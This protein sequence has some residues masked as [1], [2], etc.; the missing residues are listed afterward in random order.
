MSCR[1]GRIGAADPSGQVACERPG[2]RRPARGQDG[3]QAGAGVYDE[4]ARALVVRDEDVELTA[5]VG[6]AGLVLLLTAAGLSLVHGGR[7]P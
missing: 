1:W 4:L 3:S 2:P 5:L 7:L 6:A